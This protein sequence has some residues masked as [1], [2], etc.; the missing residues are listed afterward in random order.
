MAW[1]KF[2]KFMAYLCVGLIP[3]AFVTGLIAFI[4]WACK[5]IGELL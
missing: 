4:I 1:D 3:I 5:T 2:V